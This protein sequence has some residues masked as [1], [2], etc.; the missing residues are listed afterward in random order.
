MTLKEM[1]AFVEGHF[2][3]FVNKKDLS[4]AERSF[5]HDFYDHDEATDRSRV[6]S[7]PRR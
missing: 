7:R 6:S 5:T 2:E 1:K 4:Q 3:N